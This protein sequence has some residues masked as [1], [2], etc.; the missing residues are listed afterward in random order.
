MQLMGYCRAKL[1]P[2]KCPRSIE[3]R[4][5]LPRSATGKLFKRALRAEYWT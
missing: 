3:F 4:D 5:E 2:I 1:S